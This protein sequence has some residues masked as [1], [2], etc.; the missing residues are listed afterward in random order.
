MSLVG[1]L[2]D[3]PLTDIFQIV[4]LSK[5]TGVLNIA[6]DGD[7][8]SITFLDGNVI[9]VTS[10]K[11]EVSL[12]FLLKRNGLITDKDEA[13]ALLEQKKTREPFG[14]VLVRKNIVPKDRMEVFLREYIQAVIVDLIAWEKG[15]FEFHLLS[16]PEEI[17]PMNGSELVLDGGIDTQH[18]VIEGLRILDESRHNAGKEAS[19]QEKSIGFASLMEEPPVSLSEP[20]TSPSAGE[21]EPDDAGVWESFQDEIGISDDGPTE[22]TGSENHETRAP[23]QGE[24]NDVN[25]LDEIEYIAASGEKE[26]D[27]PPDGREDR[28]DRRKSFLEDLM[29]E[30]GDEI[31]IPD[32]EGPPEEISSL[33]SMM[34]ELR[35]PNSLSEVLLLLLRYASDFLSRAVLF[36]TNAGEIRGFGQFGLEGEDQDANER[37]RNMVIPAGSDSVLATA[38]KEGSKIRRKLDTKSPWDLKLI[39]NL[40]GNTPEESLVI[41]LTSGNK[42]IAL[43][44]GDNG[45][46]ESGIGNIDALE[47]FVIQAG[48]V[49]DRSLLERKLEDMQGA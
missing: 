36:V 14:T 4:S 6:A 21:P 24:K 38:L 32:A 47:I 28:A 8:A 45:S 37:I 17:Y 33:K 11:N 40:G 27:L 5:R 19:E 3:L 31:E 15:Q 10:T 41:P 23:T 39:E 26:A 49:L 12:G 16:S 22:P 2:A 46:H 13:A 35:E 29:L 30:V 44:Y 34:E 7:K 42:T 43:L 18:L 25:F 1:N 20:E 9:K 48:V